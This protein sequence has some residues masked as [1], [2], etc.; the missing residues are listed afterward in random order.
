MDRRFFDF[1]PEKNRGARLRFI[2]V[3][4]YWSVK[5]GTEDVWF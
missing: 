2:D 3:R 4:L 5:A 1:V